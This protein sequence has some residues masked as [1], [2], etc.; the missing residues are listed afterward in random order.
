M[1][2]LVFV[3]ICGV[4]VGAAIVTLAGCVVDIGPLAAAAKC[5]NVPATVNL[6]E[7]SEYAVTCETH[8]GPVAFCTVDYNDDDGAQVTAVCLPACP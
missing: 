4:V 5:P 6:C 3:C 2:K 7:G 8:D 1:G